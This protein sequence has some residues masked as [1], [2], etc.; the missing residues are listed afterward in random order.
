VS[1]DATVPVADVRVAARAVLEAG[2]RPEGYTVPNRDVYPFQ[3]LW[4]SC[5]HAI[6]WCELDEPARA[7]AELAHL[8][9]M[10]D[11]MGFVPHVDYEA[12]P[13]TH[14]AFWGRAGASSITQPPMYGHALAE[15]ARRGVP[16][17]PG[18]CAKATAGLRFLL[19]CRARD[20]ASGLITIVH[21]WESG[22]DDSPRW[23][24]WR[25]E[26]ALDARRWYETKGS[27]LDTI[28]RS[29]SGAPLANPAFAPAPAGFNALVAFNALELATVTRDD[30]LRSAAGAL[31]ERLV[32]RWS[33]RLGTWV[34]G[35][36]AESGS[37]SLRVLDAL[38]A[39]LVE[40]RRAAAVL[41]ALLDDGQY[42]GR[43][44]PAGVHRDEPSFAPDTY[45][46]GPA[47]P[48]LTYLFWVGARRGSFTHA[49]ES[50]ATLLV[51]G[52]RRSGFAEYWNP[53]PGAPLGARPQGWAALAAVVSPAADSTVATA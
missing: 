38:L 3:W 18:L 19:D 2:W 8:F 52:V 4:D 12:A 31:A 42:G 30:A 49:A 25:D 6:A 13:D 51:E 36:P 1:G 45:W 24:H 34:D 26:R 16:V 50:L 5:F 35:G 40:P 32:E 23:D 9:R 20:P 11:T 48:Q 33:D 17:D 47:W 53:D 37:G 41:R 27:L 21:P 22:A 43:C 29:E 14:A 28:V 39:V 44:G 15:L 7:Q 46:R 10:Q